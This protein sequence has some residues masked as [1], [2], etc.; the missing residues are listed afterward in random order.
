[1]IVEEL[2]KSILKA[3]I[4]GQLSSKHSTDSDIKETLNNIKK[5]RDELYNNKII[6]KQQYLVMTNNNNYRYDYPKDWE[7]TQIGYLGYVVGGGTPKTEIKEYWGNDYSWIT[8][9]DMKSFTDK[10]ID[11]GSRSISELGL[12]NSSAQ[13]I[14]SGAV[15]CSSRAPIG[16]LGISKNE[17]TTNQGF[18]TLVPLGNID[19]EY[20]YY[21]LMAR[22]DELK[23]S[24]DGT[25]FSEISG[26]DLAKFHIA[27]PSVEEQHRIVK[28]IESLFEKLET[29]RPLED[30]LNNEKKLFSAKMI[31]SILSF[32]YKDNEEIE[33][34]E[35]EKI[36]T[37]E[38]VKNIS[39][40]IYNYLDVQ[41]IRNLENESKIEEGR[42]VKKGDLALLMD[43]EN[44]GELFKIPE[45]GYLGSTLKK[46]T[47]SSNIIEKYLIYYLKLKQDYFKG[48]KRGAAI[49]HLDKKLFKSAKIYIPSIDEQQRIVKKIEQLLPLCNEIEKLVNS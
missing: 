48:N 20:V 36:V 4:T 40:G 41:Y 39:N 44:S 25:T 1:M 34:I 17:L 35:L 49:P 15:M 42:F 32:M 16:Y 31:K 43:G 19:P 11:V 27:L 2:K 28:K 24:G 7:L 6:T 14:P 8:P 47:I 22:V 38:N 18:K 26:A 46:I 29:I 13:L 23:K 33:K 45:D 30:E 3:A 21:Y 9:K 10:Y 12:K 5:K 37:F